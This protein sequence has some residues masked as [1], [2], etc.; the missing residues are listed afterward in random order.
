[1]IRFYCPLVSAAAVHASLCGPFPSG[2]S[3]LHLSPLQPGD[4]LHI[5]P[6]RLHHPSFHEPCDIRFSGREVQDVL[7]P[8]PGMSVPKHCEGQTGVA[9]N[10]PVGKTTIFGVHKFN[11]LS[12]DEGFYLSVD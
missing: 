4:P 5:L 12:V 11:W 8:V 1:M 7:D 10:E 2:R 3:N 9:E 6:G